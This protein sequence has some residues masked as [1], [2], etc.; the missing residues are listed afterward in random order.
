MDIK[1]IEDLIDLM[2]RSDLA[3]FE[4]E[5]KDLKLRICRNTGKGMIVSPPHLSGELPPTVSTQSS[6]S[7]PTETSIPNEEK[8]IAFI[9]SP[10]VGTFYRAPS[11]EAEPFIEIGSNVKTDTPVCI[12]EAMKVMN[13]IQAE[14]TGKIVEMLVEDGQPVEYGQALFKIKT[15]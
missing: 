1:K 6:T 14:A 13:E 10:M 7:T 15:D 12:I 11:P 2:E 9:E 3:E 5:E 4:I 8:G